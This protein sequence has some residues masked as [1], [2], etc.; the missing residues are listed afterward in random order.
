MRVL[1]TE[2]NTGNHGIEATKL[3]AIK[4][5]IDPCILILPKK[6][7]GCMAW[8]IGHLVPGFKLISSTSRW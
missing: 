1:V 8:N 3:N 6:I 5:D 4:N 2:L 7:L